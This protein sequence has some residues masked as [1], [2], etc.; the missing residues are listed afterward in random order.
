MKRTDKNKID[1]PIGISKEDKILSRRIFNSINS[2][3]ILLD[4]NYNIAI[5][6]SGG[7]DSTV[8][9]HATSKSMKL[10]GK[11]AKEKILIYVNHNL[12]SLEEIKAD[13]N[14][15]QSLAKDIGFNSNILDIH[16][17]KDNN[18]QSEARNKR[19]T[20][21][22]SIL[23][24]KDNYKYVMLAH[25]ANDMVETMLFQF[26]TGRVPS[27]I[28][29]E[30]KWS[31]NIIFIRPLLSFTREELERYAKAWSLNWIEDSSNS[32]NKY[33]RNI[34]RHDLIPF[35][36][37][38]INPGLIKSLLGKINIFNDEKSPKFF[39]KEIIK[40]NSGYKCILS[41]DPNNKYNTTIAEFKLTRS[42]YF[43][44]FYT[45][46][47]TNPHMKFYDNHQLK[48]D[49]I[50]KAAKE[51]EEKY[52]NFFKVFNNIIVRF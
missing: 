25:H 43:S 19:Y 42:Y 8:L 48:S 33:T 40:S 46:K 26:F 18:I 5:A 21:I 6:C 9:S 49:N 32:T 34:I 16:I 22:S 14:H 2:S 7:L 1:W 35:I 50:I 11:E 39:G 24:V 17:D 12:R 37:N 20:K 45:V 13:I 44:S 23:S 36:E 3:P 27:G 29:K 30:L 51:I 52:I 10:N 15:V 38:K 31:N 28:S 41:E 47:I 4:N